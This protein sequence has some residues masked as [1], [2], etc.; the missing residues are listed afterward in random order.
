MARS[1]RTFLTDPDGNTLNRDIQF[2]ANGDFQIVEGL[3]DVSERVSAYL[4]TNL[5]E[6]LYDGTIGVN[7]KMY[8]QLTETDIQL[9]RSN[10]TERLLTIPDIRT[11]NDLQ[12]E[13]RENRT[14]AIT[15]ILTAISGE[16]LT[17]SA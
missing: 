15:A 14:L 11:V 13:F 10:L 6:Y 9:I 16:V 12:V 3:E 7:Y 5:G 4:L 17:V 2:T 1:I 8:R